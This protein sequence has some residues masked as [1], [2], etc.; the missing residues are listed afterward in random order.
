[1]LRGCTSHNG[2][3]YARGSVDDYNHFA[4]VT[5]DPGW[6]WD[7][8]L[9]YFFKVHTM[10][11]DPRTQ[12]MPPER[13]WTPPVDHHKMLGQFDPTVQSTTVINVVGLNGF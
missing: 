4:A 8:L 6:T 10:S 3:V 1:I 5:G 7:C 9:L 11:I 13:K 12:F 2:M